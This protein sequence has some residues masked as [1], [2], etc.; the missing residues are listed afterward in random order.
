MESQD[1]NGNNKQGSSSTLLYIL[2]GAV[3]VLIIVGVIALVAAFSLRGGTT[4]APEAT[5]MPVP[6]VVLPT[7]ELT[8]LPTQPNSSP[9]PNATA[10][11]PTPEPQSPTAV[12]SAA[13]G[14]NV[15]TGPGS[16][17]PVVGVARFGTEGRVTGRSVDG[18]WWVVFVPNAP[19]AQ[20]WVSAQFV[21]VTNVDG[22]PI[23]PAPPTPT[24]N[25]TATPTATATATAVPSLT[26]TA[27]RTVINQGECTTLRWRVENIQ[28][29][30]VYR[31]GE[32]YQNFPVTGEGSRTE[33]PTVTTTYEMRVLQR[34]GSVVLQQLTIQ[35]NVTNPLAST[36]WRLASLNGDNVPVPGSI[37]T[38]FFG[39]DGRI[40]ING[41]CNTL[42]GTYSVNG[43]SIIIGSLSGT[44]ILCEDELMQQELAYTIALQAA[45]SY[46]IIGSQLI[47]RNAAGQE[48]LRFDRIG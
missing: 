27:D 32:T 34:D 3:V 7:L 5:S 40:N 22:V 41:G 45:A 2:I 33:C 37:L 8:P 42:N 43:S 12:V 13:N 31:L 39:A 24:P 11:L 29:V 1:N 47:V 15:R 38:A 48:I 20:G 28:A 23:I 26:F 46:Q 19:N 36:N 9:T 14:V 4:A 6:E 21:D 10:V 17:Y 44:Q 16:V 35:V 25:S 30:W 18:L